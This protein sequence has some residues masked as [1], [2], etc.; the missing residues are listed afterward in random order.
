[1]TVTLGDDCDVDPEHPLDPWLEAGFSDA[2]L[3]EWLGAPNPAEVPGLNEPLDVE[4]EFELGEI[5]DGDDP[6]FGVEVVAPRPLGGV[7]GV[8]G[9]ALAGSLSSLD[10][11]GLSPAQLVEAMTGAERL[12]RWAQGVQLAAVKAFADYAVITNEDTRDDPLERLPGGRR[13]VETGFGTQREI[14]RFCSDGIGAALGTSFTAGQQLID[15]AYFAADV[16]R[17]AAM[18]AAG[19]IDVARLKVLARELAP[20]G[21]GTPEDQALVDALVEASAELTPKK[22]QVDARTAV[23]ASRPDGQEQ[24]HRREKRTR[25]V[26]VHRKPSGMATLCAY[27]TAEEAQAAYQALNAQA[28]RLHDALCFR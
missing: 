5:D 18:L 26:W 27:L 28:W 23:M 9:P 10:L 19:L 7:T 6:W 20:V 24:A 25:G 16:P 12:A 15:A 8:A 1:M 17:A 14:E 11:A 22:L 21:Y 13:V 3:E 2:E 4:F